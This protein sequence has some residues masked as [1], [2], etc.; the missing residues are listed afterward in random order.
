MTNGVSLSGKVLCGYQGWYRTPGDGSGSDWVHYVRATGHAFEPG[1]CG[2]DYWPDVTELDP[3]ER[4]PTVFKHADGHPAQVYSSH[5][6]KTVLRHFK[7]MR[8]YGIDGVFVQRFMTDVTSV[9]PLWKTLRVSN[10]NILDWCR[11]AAVQ[12]GRVYSVMYDLTGMPRKNGV[13]YLKKDWKDLVDSG[14]VLVKGGDAAWLRHKGRPVI[15]LWGVGFRNDAMNVARHY[16]LDECAQLINFFKNDPQYGG[17]AVLIGVPGYWRTLDR[18]SI[19][20]PRLHQVMRLAD[21]IQPWSIGRFNS[22]EGG[23]NFAATVWKGDLEWCRQ[24]GLDYLP[25]TFP[26]FSWQNLKKTTAHEIP[27]LGGRFLWAQYA[28][29]RKLGLDSAYQAMFDE[30]DEGTQIFKIDNNPP[31]GAITFK[32]YEGL[33]PDHYLWLVGQA[34]RLLRGE[35]P[36]TDGFPVRTVEQGAK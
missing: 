32:T 16:G 5:N 27:R 20:D 19:A 34:G 12:N 14:K 8:E 4:I 2:I 23:R 36:L 13:E 24:N 22:I 3:D 1:T 26:G 6:R 17:C 15:G 7:W 29:L 35:I 11:E 18:D 31:V 25:V 33:P 21:I 9:H 30:M 28:E 10:N